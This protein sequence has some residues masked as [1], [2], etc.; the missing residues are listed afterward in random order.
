MSDQTPTAA[1]G[2]PRSFEAAL[3]E[4]EKIV[5]ALEDGQLGLTES[6]G[7]YERGV[8]LLRQCYHLLERAERKIE[9][10]TK[11]DEQ[12]R[13]TTSPFRDEAEAS[14]DAEK[15]SARSRRRSADKTPQSVRE[16]P[17]VDDMDEPPRLF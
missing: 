2:E 12:G 6:L 17:A 14:D 7:C 8:G 1:E 3:A 10:L 16:E 9:Q 11:V 15:R 13:P 4:L 5:H